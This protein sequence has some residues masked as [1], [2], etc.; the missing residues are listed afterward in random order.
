MV[1]SAAS[2]SADAPG[3]EEP[4]SRRWTTRRRIWLAVR[5]LAIAGLAYIAF[6]VISAN[7]AELSGAASYLEDAHADWV[8]AA[9]LAEVL[10]YAAFTQLE[11][12]LLAAGR[13]RTGVV[14]MAAITLAG[15]AINSSLPGGGAFATVFAY[16]QFRRQGADEALTTWTLVAYTALTAIALAVL[17]VLGLVVAGSDGPVGGLWPV[18]P[19]LV[20]GPSLILAMLLRPRFLERFA[21]P[22]V[23]LVRRL[24][25]Y[26]RAEP[27]LLVHRLIERLEAVSPARADWLVSLLYALLNWTTDCLCLVF[28]FWAVGAGVPWRG[29]LVAYAAAQVAANLPITPGGLGVVEGSLTVALVVYGGP[30]VGSVAAVLLYRIISFWAMLPVGWMAWL[31]L[32][33]HARR[34]PAPGVVAS[35]EAEVAGGS[36]P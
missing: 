24:T 3:G 11:R 29:L 13:V 31:G 6:L 36:A 18:V 25:G 8:V 30:K 2:V 10:S 15:N 19:V 22:P 4:G 16:N 35:V 34:R 20:I 21:T 33:L 5:L 32:H 27:T 9:I 26:P 1:V 23:R 7:S 17:S 12:R 28:S 14:P